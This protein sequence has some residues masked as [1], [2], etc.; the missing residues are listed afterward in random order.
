MM[1]QALANLRA[2]VA[3]AKNTGRGALVNA[4]DLQ[5]LID[6]YEREHPEF[7]GHMAQFDRQ[8]STARRAGLKQSPAELLDGFA[9]GHL[10]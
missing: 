8:F 3:V 7:G 9:E 6:A 2:A 10:S 4:D 1:R 5:A